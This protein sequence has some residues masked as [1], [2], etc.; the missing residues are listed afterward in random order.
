VG[1]LPH[2]A[3]ILTQPP[4]EVRSWSAKMRAKDG[5]G[6]AGSAGSAGGAGGGGGWRRKRNRGKGRGREGAK[7]EERKE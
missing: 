6:G 5:G 3:V 7:K 1:P 4:P 2:S